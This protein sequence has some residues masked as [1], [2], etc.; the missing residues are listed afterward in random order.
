[1][2]RW[3]YHVIGLEHSLDISDRSIFVPRGSDRK[4]VWVCSVSSPKEV[5]VLTWSNVVC[6]GWRLESITRGLVCMT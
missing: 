6:T 1:M 4:E 5:S 2:P 3:N